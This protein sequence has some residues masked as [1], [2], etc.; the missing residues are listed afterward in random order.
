MPARLRQLLPLALLLAATLTLSIAAAG[1][2]TLP[3]DVR[4]TRWLQANPIPFADPLTG[5]TND[6]VTGRPL[7]IVGMAL[8]IALLV[9][10]RTDAALLIALATLLRATNA[11]LKAVFDSPRP[12]P[13]VVSVTE[14][15][16]GLGFPSGH[17]MGAALLLGAL[18][19]LSL[20]ASVFS[21]LPE[22]EGPT[23]GVRERPSPSRS[24]VRSHRFGPA[25]FLGRA[26]A[27]GCLALILLTSYGRIY[28]G[29]HWPSD[30]LGGYLWGTLLLTAA[31]QLT[32]VATR[33]AHPSARGA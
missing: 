24:A 18:A 23:Q 12:T 6:Y 19:Y 7:T 1:D 29:A 17:A 15:P 10:R 14:R 22:G 30:V 9:A 4:L 28:T 33:R 21:P 27:F 5:F 13:D 25:R 8:T 20:S 31:I 32:R 16:A 2:G 3:A 11:A 26:A